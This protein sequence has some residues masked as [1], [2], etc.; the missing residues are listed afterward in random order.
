MTL[1]Y[2]L[3]VPACYGDISG[4]ISVSVTGIIPP[5]QYQWSVPG[6]PDTSQISGLSAG[7]YFLTVTQTDSAIVIIDTVILYGNNPLTVTMLPHNTSCSGKTDGIINTITSGGTSPY[8]YLWSTGS[9]LANLDSL[10]MGNYKV[11]VTDSSGCQAYGDV[12]IM[13]DNPI[14][15]IDTIT[16][17]S[18]WG[19]WNGKMNL[20]PSGGILPYTFVWDMVDS[21]YTD[22]AHVQSIMDTVPAQMYK[23]TITDSAGCYVI[24]SYTLTQP[25]PMSI[26]Y[27][28]INNKCFNG[29]AGSATVWALGGIIGYTFTWSNND[30]GATSDSLRAGTYK[31][32][33]KDANSCSV[34]QSIEISQPF[35]GILVNADIIDVSCRDQHDGEIHVKSVDNVLSPY[36][37]NW[38]SGVT[39]NSLNNLDGGDYV[40]TVTDANNCI[41][42]DTFKVNITDI[43]CIEIYTC[44]S[45]NGDEVND[46]WN[47]KNINLYPN[48]E[49]SVFNQWS[50][51]LLNTKGYLIPWDGKYKGEEMPAATYYY[52]ITLG[53]DRYKPYTGPVTIIK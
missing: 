33:V 11:T 44:F 1:N 30:I 20:T 17:I 49:V 29:M 22:T 6:S 10:V 39:L 18:C 9:I 38:S 43:D 34:V 41:S 27:T 2:S 51:L 14:L 7:I 21:I 32:T 24:K 25:V 23:V 37:Y 13:T 16:N 3:T 47:I 36:T 19:G 45:P 40:L 31:V 50:H 8:F 42:V 35:K 4:A 52:V 15:T 5:F 48:C 46:V 53:D 26:G 12:N 28:Q